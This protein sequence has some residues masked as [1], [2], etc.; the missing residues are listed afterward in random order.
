VVLR[1]GAIVSDRPQ[2]TS[3]AVSYELEPSGRYSFE[4]SGVES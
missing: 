1:D 3:N 2:S 4:A